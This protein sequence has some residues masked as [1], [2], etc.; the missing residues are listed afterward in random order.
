[1]TGNEV[2]AGDIID[3]NSARIAHIIRD[4]GYQIY[5]K[6]TVGDDLPLL[7]RLILELSDESDVLIMNGGLGPTRDDFTAQAMAQAAGVELEENPIAKAHLEKIAEKRGLQ[8]N[9]SNLKQIS[10]PKGCATVPN[11]KGTALG[12]H[13]EINGCQVYCTS[14]VPMELESMVKETILPDIRERFPAGEVHVQKMISFGIGESSL[15][16]RIIEKFG[17]NA[18]DGS[19][20]IELGFRAS[21]PY[22][23]LKLERRDEGN[24]VLQK[25]WAEKL[26][27]L[28][29]GYTIEDASL[30]LAV[31]RIL[32]EK[33]K[34]LT[35]AESCTGGL[36]AS[37]LTTIPGAS[38]IFHAGFVVY[39]DEIKNTVLGVSE[40]TLKQ[41]GAVSEQTVIEMAEGALKLSQSDYVIAVSGIAGPDGGTDEKPVGTVWFAF[42]DANNLQT[43][44]MRIKWGR[45]RF[46]T[47]TA[48]AGLDLIRRFITLKNIDPVY[49]FDD[50]KRK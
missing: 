41:Q 11:P 18:L 7:S 39:S 12:M 42:G 22:V 14:G 36:I 21:L 29:A 4:Y 26:R 40:E 43:R 48:A 27:Q 28:F 2:M 17:T 25:A 16:T 1:M 47:I 32:K 35:L 20:G 33:K 37:Q 30:P 5:K 38:E 13:M 9:Q 15:Q 34:T 3:S 19:D 45:E 10:L 24:A 44:Q 50:Y 8:L 23:E 6:V 46:Q 49:S 31:H